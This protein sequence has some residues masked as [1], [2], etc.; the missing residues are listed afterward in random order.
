[1]AV[2]KSARVKGVPKKIESVLIV[3]LAHGH[4]IGFD[5]HL[6]KYQEVWAINNAGKTY[7]IKPTRIVAMDDLQ[8][9]WD[10]V[11]HK[12]YVK[13]I[14]KAGVPVIGAR[15]HRQWPAVV[16]YPLKEVVRWIGRGPES[17]RLLDNT[18]NYALALAL[19]C[20]A[21]RI[22]LHGIW[23]T[24]FDNEAIL[25]ASREDFTARGYLYVPD[26]F[27]YYGHATLCR[28]RPSEPGGEAFHFWLGY[29]AANGVKI[30]FTFPEV[31][32]LN[33]DRDRYFYGHQEQPKL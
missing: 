23:F 18:V 22:G 7:G 2:K 17:C 16:P 31:P 25:A 19:K 15:K 27:K 6:K 20:G 28:R 8:R 29:A 1:M 21:K 12:D 30:E 26:W 3:G 14:V 9:D 24:A 11:I 13:S 32:V 10:T 4:F 5:H 33:Q